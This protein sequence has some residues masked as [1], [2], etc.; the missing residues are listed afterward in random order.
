MNIF[1]LG[2]FAGARF[3]RLLVV[4]LLMLG[5][6]VASVTAQSAVNESAACG[7]S[8]HGS[9]FIPVDSWIYPAVLRLYS[10]GYMDSTFLGVRPW[11]RASV[12]HMLAT[13]KEQL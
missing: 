3:G 1:Q 13:L 7:T 2:D 10:L 11:T 4:V 8:V 9:P 6:G 5:V 12:E